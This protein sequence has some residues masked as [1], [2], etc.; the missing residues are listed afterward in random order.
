M[1][2]RSLTRFLVVASLFLLLAP[3]APA[4]APVEAEDLN[5]QMMRATVKIMHEK[6]TATGFILTKAPDQHILVTANHIFD[7]TPGDQTEIL[8]RQKTGEGEYKRLPLKITIRKDGKPTWTKHPTQDIAV[9]SIKPPEN[10]D[11]PDLSVDLLATDALLKKYKVH[12]GE[13]LS[14]NGYPHRNESNA[15]GFAILRAGTLSSFP[16]TPTAKTL[17]F[18]MDSNIFEGDSGSGVYLSRTSG[19]G[20]KEEVRLIV[21]LVSAQMF[22]DEELKTV[23]SVSKT[24]HRLGLAIVIHASLIKET[25]DLLK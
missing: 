13:K 19:D 6:S 25:V 4:Q 17:H 22:L 10:A 14:Y 18:L 11:L 20:S 7:T 3:A 8:F 9:I 24:R 12:P 23:Y 15:E 2:C 5:T 16:L 21:G 1:R